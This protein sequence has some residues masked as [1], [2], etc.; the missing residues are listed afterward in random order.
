LWIISE[1]GYTYNVTGLFGAQTAEAF[2]DTG[3]TCESLEGGAGVDG[4]CWATGDA[5]VEGSCEGL[6]ELERRPHWKGEGLFRVFLF[7]YLI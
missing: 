7:E 2:W 5:F 3:R 6:I 4:S 1:W